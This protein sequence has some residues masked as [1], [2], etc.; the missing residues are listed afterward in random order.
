MKTFRIY[1]RRLD[2]YSATI[3]AESKAEALKLYYQDDEETFGD[4]WEQEETIRVF[5]PIIKEVKDENDF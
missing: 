3:E 5:K 4:Q 2:L 1:E